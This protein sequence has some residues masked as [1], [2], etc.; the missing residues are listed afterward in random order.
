MLSSSLLFR[1]S[2]FF[3]VSFLPPLRFLP[4]LSSPEEKK[5]ADDTRFGI[6][7]LHSDLHARNRVRLKL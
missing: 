2:R 4:A 5:R 7:Y 6:K 1:A 3:A